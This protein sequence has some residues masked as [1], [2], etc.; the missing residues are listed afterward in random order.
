MSA[1]KY[2]NMDKLRDCARCHSDQGPKP[3]SSY[4]Q[5][6]TSRLRRTT[7]QVSEAAWL[8]WRHNRRMRIGWQQRLLTDAETALRHAYAPY[9]SLRVGAAVLLES[10]GSYAGC[11]VENDSYG[12]TICAERAAVFAAVAAE[13]E[14]VDLVKHKSKGIKIRGIAI[15]ASKPGAIVAPCGAC[16]QVIAQFGPTAIVIYR[17]GEHVKQMSIRHLLPASFVLQ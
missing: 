11:N 3:V 5:F 6:G 1:K 16:R 17:A 4:L 15:A 9:S 2:R 14:A 13:G 12:L 7:G 8:F 10:G